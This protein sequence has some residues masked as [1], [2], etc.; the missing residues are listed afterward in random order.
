MEGEI[1]L[2]AILDV[3][4]E[5]REELGDPNASF[6]QKS[7]TAR[8]RK[9]LR[10]R[11]SPAPCVRLGVSSLGCWPDSYLTQ[12]I[13]DVSTSHKNPRPLKCMCWFDEP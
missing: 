2:L 11:G 8:G 9:G 5:K 13:L 6:E 12:R 1:A 4:A 10:Q 3:E 7:C